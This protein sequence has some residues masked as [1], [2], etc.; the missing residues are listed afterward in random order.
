[1]LP[2]ALIGRLAVD[3]R[4][5]GPSLGAALLFDAIA[6]AVRAD[7]AVFT[8]IV[9]AKDDAAARFYRHHGF[10][11]FQAGRRGRFFRWQ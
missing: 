1:M 9:D 4:Y 8:L 7:A 10:T 2:A 11:H 3:R 6:R 5:Q